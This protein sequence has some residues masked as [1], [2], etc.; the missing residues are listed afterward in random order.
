MKKKVR[1]DFIGGL[2]KRGKIKTIR[3]LSN[4]ERRENINNF[5]GKRISSIMVREEGLIMSISLEL[6]D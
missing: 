1:I 6:E 5:M 3:E 4:S 2:G